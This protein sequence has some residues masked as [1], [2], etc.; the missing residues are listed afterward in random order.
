MAKPAQW[1]QEF[2]AQV[3]AMSN[4]VLLDE[5]LALAPGDDYD[6]G[7]TN[8]GSWRYSLMLYVFYNRLLKAGF[9]AEADRAKMQDEN[10]NPG[11]V[12]AWVLGLG[13]QYDE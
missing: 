13:V 4:G 3:R 7:M 9:I 10:Y 6:G 11:L 1:Q 5:L 2:I 8:R 12:D